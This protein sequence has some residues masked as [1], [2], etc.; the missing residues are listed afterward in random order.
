[1]KTFSTM[2]VAGVVAYPD[3]DIGR[4]HAERHADGVAFRRA[5]EVGCRREHHGSGLRGRRLFRRVV[6]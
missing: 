2:L 1:M 6:R 5:R 4:Q 3:G